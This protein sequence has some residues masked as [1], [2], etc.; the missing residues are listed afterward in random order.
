LKCECASNEKY[1]FKEVPV[2]PGIVG[3]ILFLAGL[4]LAFLIMPVVIVVG[5]V[6]ILPLGLAYGLYQM[7]RRKEFFGVLKN[8]KKVLIIDDD[9]DSALVTAGAFTS[10]GWQTDIATTP[11]MALDY[12]YYGEPGLVVLDW[13][14]SPVL[15]GRELLKNATQ[16]FTGERERQKTTETPIPVPVVS[17]SSS[18]LNTINYD[19]SEFFKHTES[20]QKPY[21]FS[22]LVSAA[23]RIARCGTA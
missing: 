12:L 8:S 11:A 9:I 2:V 18:P 7:L 1:E 5:L 10:A 3:A 13:I 20:W 16:T 15:N 19:D 6:S 21:R 4:G 23:G 17:L 22:E 14:L